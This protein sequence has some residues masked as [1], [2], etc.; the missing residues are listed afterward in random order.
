M[1]ENKVTPVRK[2]YL[3]IKAKHQNEILFFRLGDFYETFDEDAEIV[4]KELETPYGDIIAPI[5]RPL[6]AVGCCLP[7]SVWALG[8]RQ[9]TLATF[10]LLTA[11]FVLS[12][13][14]AVLVIVADAAE[15]RQVIT[16]LRN[17]SMSV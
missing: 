16:L 3:D 13:L 9:W 5:V 12:Y 2:Q 1:S 6:I 17:C 7:V 15:R 8:V 14:V 10:L 4:S 11:L